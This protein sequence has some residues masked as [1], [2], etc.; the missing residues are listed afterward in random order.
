MC[1][2]VCVCVCEETCWTAGFVC[3]CVCVCVK[4]SSLLACITFA[5]MGGAQE[6]LWGSP[7]RP[8]QGGWA[9]DQQPH[10]AAKLKK[11]C[12]T[13]GQQGVRVCVCVCLKPLLHSRRVCVC[14]SENLAG[15]QG[16]RVCGCVC[17]CLKPLH[18]VCV[19]V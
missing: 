2:C 5:K 19:C 6:L 14:V 7:H 15:Q 4:T 12:W 13:S 10:L 1:V 3:V 11:T 18:T 17:V 16:V 8:E 9:A